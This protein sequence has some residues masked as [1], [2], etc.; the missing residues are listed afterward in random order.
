MT[1]TK[2]S[3]LELATTVSAQHARLLE[4]LCAAWVLKKRTMPKVVWG[5]VE[6]CDADDEHPE[7][8]W[9]AESD[10]PQPITP[11]VYEH[12]RMVLTGAPRREWYD[13]CPGSA[14]VYVQRH[15]DSVSV[16]IGRFESG[17]V[18]DTVDTGFRIHD[19]TTSSERLCPGAYCEVVYGHRDERLDQIPIKP[20]VFQP[21]AIAYVGGVPVY[22]G[23]LQVSVGGKMVDVPFERGESAEVI[24]EKVSKAINDALTEFEHGAIVEVP[25]FVAR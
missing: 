23:T 7:A 2:R 12:A 8:A 21:E 22:D 3:L 17:P 16:G 6:C 13:D 25:Q 9:L 1:T 15:V 24:A 10:P 4:R 11:E 5:C 20:F 19:I 18:R 14:Y